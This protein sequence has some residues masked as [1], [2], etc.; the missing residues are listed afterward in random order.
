M[1]TIEIMEKTFQAESGDVAL[2]LAMSKKAADEGDNDTARY[3]YN[4]AMDEARHAA[5]FAILLGKVK[6]TR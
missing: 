5:E 4:V 1:Q 3:F 2:Y 6:D